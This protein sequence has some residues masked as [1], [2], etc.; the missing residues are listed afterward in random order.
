MVTTQSAPITFDIPL[1]RDCGFYPQTLKKSLR[2]ERVLM[3]ALPEM[4]VQG[5][6]IRK[7]A[8]TE[9]LCGSDVFPSQVSQAASLSDEVLE[10]WSNPPL[11][12]I[13]YLYLDPIY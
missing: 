4:Y 1:V 8:V 12:K 3:L 10:A 9:R 5:V 13:I 2:S 11:V 7:V 6:S